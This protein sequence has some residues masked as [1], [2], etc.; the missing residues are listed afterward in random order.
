[1]EKYFLGLMKHTIQKKVKKNNSTCLVVS[2]FIATTSTAELPDGFKINARTHGI[3]FIQW[4]IAFLGR[5]LKRWK[6]CSFPFVLLGLKELY[7][8]I[9]HCQINV[10]LLFQFYH[11]LLS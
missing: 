11:R 5:L 7:F 8:Y 9:S 2:I 4:I 10:D 6:I 1:M 3:S